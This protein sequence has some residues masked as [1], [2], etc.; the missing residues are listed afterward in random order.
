MSPLCP[1]LLTLALLAVPGVRGA[2][3]AS[4]DLNNADGTRT[5]AKLYDKSDP[6]YENCCAGAVLSLEPGADLPYLPS[7]LVGLSY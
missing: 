2:C 5:C 4:A 3:P 6:Y 7:D 1:L